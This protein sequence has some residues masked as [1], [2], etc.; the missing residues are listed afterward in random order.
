MSWPEFT[1]RML[2]ALAVSIRSTFRHYDQCVYA[3]DTVMPGHYADRPAQHIHYLISA[4]RPQDASH[5]SLLRR[6]P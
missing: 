1:A 5:A 3:V 6:R 2:C 4:A